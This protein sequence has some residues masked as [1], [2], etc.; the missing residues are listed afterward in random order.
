MLN[1]TAYGIYRKLSLFS[2][3]MNIKITTGFLHSTIIY[4]NMGGF[5]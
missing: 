2:L 4:P 5:D 3:P 1:M